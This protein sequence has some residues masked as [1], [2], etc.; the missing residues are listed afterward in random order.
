MRSRFSFFPNR[1]VCD[2][3]EEMRTCTKTGYYRYL[4]GLIEEVQSMTN[5]M[6]AALYDNKDIKNARDHI[7]E[8]KTEIEKLEKQKEALDETL[9]SRKN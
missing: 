9:G 4:P 6:E 3:L 7:K 5:R 1:T 8:L 2:V